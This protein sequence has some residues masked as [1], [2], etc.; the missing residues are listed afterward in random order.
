LQVAIVSYIEVF[1]E[2]ASAATGKEISVRDSAG[3]IFSGEGFVLVENID[4]YRRHRTNFDF[5]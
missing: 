5:L 3:F 2:H 1:L 4:W